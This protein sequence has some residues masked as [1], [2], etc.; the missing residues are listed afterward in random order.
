MATISALPTDPVDVKVRKIVEKIF[1]AEL[2]TDASLLDY[3]LDSLTGNTLYITLC[4]SIAVQ[5]Q[6]TLMSVF[7]LP[8]QYFSPTL[9]YK[10]AKLSELITYTTEIT[11]M[12]PEERMHHYDLLSSLDQYEVIGKNL[13]ECVKCGISRG[14]LSHVDPKEGA[15]LLTG[16][17]GFLG[18]YILYELLTKSDSLIYCVLRS[19]GNNKEKQNNKNFFR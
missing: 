1:G 12:N 6:A 11:S 14:K 16:A 15:I 3:G 18:N 4:L 7:G 8:P 19:H 10:F 5:L 9:L 13:P 17:R 2:E